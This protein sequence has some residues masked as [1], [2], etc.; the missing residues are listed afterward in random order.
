MGALVP[1]FFEEGKER[2]KILPRYIRNRFLKIFFFCILSVVLIFL[3]VDLVEEFDRFIDNDVSPRIT[4]LYYIYY[5]PYVIV[6]SLP[7]ASLLATVFSVGSFARQ[8]E[9][10]AMKALGYSLYQVMRPLVV[11]GLLISIVSFAIAEGVAV[12]ATRKKQNIRRDYLGRGKISSRLNHLEIQ[13]PPD[14]IITIGYYDTKNNVAHRVKIETYDAE[15]RLVSRLDAP[16]MQWIENA[17][18]VARGFQREF[19][20]ETETALPV[21]EAV[22]FHFQFSPD[23]LIKAQI[24][25]DEMTIQELLHFSRRVEQAGGEVHRWMTDYYLRVSFPMSNFVIVLLSIPIAYNRRKK[26]LTVGFGISLIVCFLY[27]GLV[28]TGQTIGQKGNMQPLLA[29]WLGNV[30]ML[31]CGLINVARTRK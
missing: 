31:G 14:K 10:V 5:T 2:M 13:E 6:L 28:K 22:R 17:W 20:G 26:S 1:T 8:N 11:L 30:V 12:S 25:P 23:E 24:K 16:T 21:D 7:I 18:V 19:D 3:V 4:F 15:H 29:A 9:V 27:F